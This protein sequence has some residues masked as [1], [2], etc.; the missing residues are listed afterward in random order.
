[1][2]V[3]LVPSL[4]LSEEEGG[5]A[6]FSSYLSK[7]V[8]E[9]ARATRECDAVQLEFFLQRAQDAKLSRMPRELHI[10]KQQL[11]N[12]KDPTWLTSELKEAVVAVTW[13]AN[14]EEDMTK[15]RNLV[16]QAQEVRKHYAGFESNVDPDVLQ[17]AVATLENL[18][19]PLDGGIGGVGRGDGGGAG[20][21]QKG[22]QFENF[23]LLKIN[24]QIQE[25]KV[26]MMRA[27][28][29]L[30]NSAILTLLVY[31]SI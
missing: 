2:C 26:W 5:E 3:F 15:L 1:M 27:S 25:T 6:L 19:G 30:Q 22:F 16:R 31:A 7:F 9:V 29:V 21:G 20:G 11:E 4:S 24:Q 18:R 8:R 17:A 12:L 14:T 23:P 10:A 13:G 28:G